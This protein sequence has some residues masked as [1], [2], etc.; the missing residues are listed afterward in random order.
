MTHTLA[1]SSTIE[2]SYVYNGAGNPT[3]M[4]HT[5]GG[6]A[7]DSASFVYDALS[8]LTQE[9][10]FINALA[11]N[12]P[13]YGSY[14]M[15]YGYTLSGELQSVTDPFGA[16]IN[17]SYD[18]AGRTTSVGGSSY[19][20]VTS[21]ASN[22]QYR[23]WGAVKSASFP[24]NTSETV[25]YN[26]RLQPTQFR[27]TS[28]DTW[29]QMRDDYNY[30]PD[31]RLKQLTDLDDTI[32]VQ[33][34]WHYMSRSYSYDR[35][36]RIAG[37]DAPL[38][39]NPTNKPPP[40]RGS[41]GYDPFDNLIIR[42]GA[43]GVHGWQSDSSTYV[44]NR[45]SGWSYDADGRV[46]G[47]ADAN[48]NSSRTWSY[49]AAGEETSVSETTASA[50]STDTMAYDG[51]G[52]MLSESVTIPGYSTSDYL[53]HSTVLGGA[54]L[55]KLTATGGKSITY[56]PAKG[57]VAPIQTENGSYYQY[58]GWIHRDA[59]GVQEG[60]SGA[61][62][63]LGN[64]IYNEQPPTGGGPATGG[65]YGPGYGGAG[66]ST[67]SNANNSSSGCMMDGRP[68]SCDAVLRS[69]NNGSATA[70]PNMTRPWTQSLAPFGPSSPSGSTNGGTPVWV[71]G[72]R[73]SNHSGPGPSGVAP[74]G[75]P[76]ERV[77]RGE[78]FGTW[79]F[80][81]TN[82][83][84]G[85]GFGMFF[86]GVAPQ[87]TTPTQPTDCQRFANMVAGIAGR[88][89][90]AEGFMDEMARTFT[91]ANNSSKEEMSRNLENAVPPDRPHIGDAGFKP[92]LRDGT[93]LQVRHFVGGMLY[94]YRY[95]YEGPMVAG[96]LSE[97]W[98]P[99]PA[100]NTADVRLNDFSMAWGASAEPR[101]ATTT[102]HM[103]VMI[104]VPAHPGYK[105]FADLIRRHI[106][107]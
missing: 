69:L 80:V 101:G 19:A 63:P 67:F 61:Y 18:T 6:T 98:T 93:D 77:N 75:T 89:N 16:S 9:T 43:N 95:G 81:D 34:Q 23:A 26:T 90:S 22:V 4:S 15:N 46:I 86:L 79:A 36:A 105:G 52:Q 78:T 68:A 91:A 1:G 32:A 47:S 99:A 28:S 62:D 88:N 94:G 41:Y 27:L 14:T 40:F 56:V 107:E 60:S 73:D 57:L 29:K 106:C 82:F 38:T 64:L 51:N 30:H 37:V 102:G 2:I 8:R 44:N 11:S 72:Q 17:Y 10:R 31:G 7:K 55:T 35:S 76:I 92:G 87:N 58:I 65:I 33:G 66:W 74:D 59:L 49:D 3:S 70:D 20:G 50:T 100:G 71:P 83:F 42:S 12:A 45:R 48:T 13:N 85:G 39:N 21:Y 24:D 5:V 96:A 103:G 25:A 53:I 104:N 97:L 84:G 54:V